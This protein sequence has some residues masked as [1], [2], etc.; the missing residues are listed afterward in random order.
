M[1]TVYF[2][3]EMDQVTKEKK[4]PEWVLKVRQSAEGDGNHTP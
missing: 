2:I 1:H 4:P 3:D